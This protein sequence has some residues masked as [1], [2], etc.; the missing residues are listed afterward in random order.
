MLKMFFVDD[1]HLEAVE[2]LANKFEI[3]ND[4]YEAD[5]IYTQLT[6]VAC[7][8][9]PNLKYVITPCTGTDHILFSEYIEVIHLDQKW[10]ETEG[11]DVLATAE[12]TWGL[13]LALIRNIPISNG[14]STKSRGY[15]MGT[16]LKGKTIGI[17][18]LGRIGSKV[19]EY[20]EAF[21]MKV[22]TSDKED[23]DFN[24]S[25]MK[26]LKESDIISIHIPLNFRTKYM[27]GYP[28]INL[29]KYGVYLINT[30]RAAV[31]NPR[32]LTQHSRNPNPCS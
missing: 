21:G 17:L 13:L 12:M 6:E 16:E 8:L 11:K 18:G 5:I 28:Q 22:I 31:I 29:M 4:R 15:Y 27:I 7:H 26:L 24:D 32:S 30:S 10:K 14:K 20:A 1:I 23:D 25:Y 9:Y 3:T 19:K 2:I